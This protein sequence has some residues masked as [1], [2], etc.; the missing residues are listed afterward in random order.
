MMKRCV[1]SLMVWSVS[2]LLAWSQNAVVEESVTEVNCESP[3]HAITHY[4]TVITILNEQGGAYRI[5]FPQAGELNGQFP[6]TDHE[7]LRTGNP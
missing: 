1:L 5:G 3:A 2:C 7:C 6:R 4:K